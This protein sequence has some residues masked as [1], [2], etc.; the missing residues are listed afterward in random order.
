MEID[1]L[2]GYIDIA[3]YLARVPGI[4]GGIVEIMEDGSVRGLPMREVIIYAPKEST[5]SGTPGEV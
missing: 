4:Y 3:S 5:E 2:F 1:E